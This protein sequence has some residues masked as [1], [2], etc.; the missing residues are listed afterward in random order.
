MSE[1]V[2]RSGTLVDWAVESH[3]AAK[4]GYVDDGAVLGQSYFDAQIGVVDRR[5]ALAAARLALSLGGTAELTNIALIPRVGP[6][7]WT[8]AYTLDM[9][10]QSQWSEA[11]TMR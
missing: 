6:P 9:G 8:R 2:W 11:Q 7:S 4:L 10:G 5:L 1:T 3:D